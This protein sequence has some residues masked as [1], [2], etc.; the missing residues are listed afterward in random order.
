MCYNFR[1]PCKWLEPIFAAAV[2]MKWVVLVPLSGLYQTIIML[3]VILYYIRVE[4]L[5][6]PAP[7]DIGNYHGR[8]YPLYVDSIVLIANGTGTLGAIRSQSSNGS[9]MAGPEHVHWRYWRPGWQSPPAIYR[10]QPESP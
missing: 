8:R 10:H 5:A 2:A 1:L 3:F 6:G 9:S 4:Q 7:A